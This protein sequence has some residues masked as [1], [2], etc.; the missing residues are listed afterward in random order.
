MELMARKYAAAVALDGHLNVEGL[1]AMADDQS[2]AMALARSISNAIDEADI[3]RNWAKVSS[4]QGSA[5]PV[6]LLELG[7]ESLE[8]DPFDGLD[9]INMEAALIAQTLLDHEQTSHT[10]LTRAMLAKMA[11]E[12]FDAD[13]MFDDLAVV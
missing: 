3:Q 12:L 1:C 2:A 5:A 13:D 10:G 4:K 8:E 6:P 7:I 9:V 11:E